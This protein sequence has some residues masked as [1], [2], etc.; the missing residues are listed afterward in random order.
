M[1]FGVQYHQYEIETQL[2]IV[3]LSHPRDTLGGL[4]S[5]DSWGLDVS[6]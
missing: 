3:I 4:E 5:E 1:W 6:M 2:F